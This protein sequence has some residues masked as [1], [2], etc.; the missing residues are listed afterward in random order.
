MVRPQNF[1]IRDHTVVTRFLEARRAR[2]TDQPGLNLSWSNWCFGPEPLRVSADRLARNGISWI[3][4]H[5]NLYG[6]DL[7]YRPNEVLGVLGDHGLRPA[8]VCGIVTPDCELS[9]NRPH[10][11]Q[12]AID[13]FRRQADFC[14]AVGGTYV[15]FGAGAVGRP[16]PYDNNE[17]ARAADTLRVVAEHFAD[18]GV[19][20]L[21]EPIRPEETSLVHTFAEARRLIDLVDHP[22]VRHING[23][24]FHMLASEEHLTT[25]LLDTG[26][27]LVNLHLADTNRRGLGRGHLDL[28]PVLMALYAIGFDAPGRFCTPEPLGAGGNPYRAMHDPPDAEALDKLVAE[29]AQC[30]YEREQEILA[31]SEEELLKS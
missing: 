18:T 13:Y 31:A 15:L 17:L 26:E 28:D 1:Q 14:A 5:G 27:F 2:G 9:S 4:L 16:T 29:T 23:D 11:R 7:G 10:V 19:R 3:E 8:G 22:G 21:V 6:P 24:I 30:F 20:G 12:R 25:T